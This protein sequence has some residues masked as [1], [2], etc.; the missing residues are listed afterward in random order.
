[1]HVRRPT[2]QRTG[3]LSLVLPLA[4]ALAPLWLVAG[5]DPPPP[6]VLATVVDVS[7]KVV[8]P[9]DVIEITGTGFVEGSARIV[10]RGTFD[11][12]GLAP[13]ERREVTLEGTAIS[14]TAIEVPITSVLMERIAVEPVEFSGVVAVS[15]PT[16]LPLSA[17]RVGAESTPLM[18]GLR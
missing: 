11:P 17:V 6:A 3:S 10:L 15:F 9:G 1:M 2:T 13:P 5:C 18:I 7:P 14:G 4:L 12:L 16:A 8:E